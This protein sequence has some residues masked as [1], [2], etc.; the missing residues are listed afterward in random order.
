[1]RLAVQPAISRRRVAVLQGGAGLR[2]STQNATHSAAR[3]ARAR[4]CRRYGGPHRAPR[5]YQRG[6]GGVRC[7]RCHDLRLSKLSARCRLERVDHCRASQE[8]RGTDNGHERGSSCRGCRGSNRCHDNKHAAQHGSVRLLFQNTNSCWEKK[9]WVGRK[10]KW[11]G[12]RK[13]CCT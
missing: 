3:D 9:K 8:T 1:M 5:R 11:I 13:K 6:G 12:R 7:F 10:K 4:V 2:G